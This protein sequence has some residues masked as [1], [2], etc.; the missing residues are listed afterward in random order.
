MYP[1]PSPEQETRHQAKLIVNMV[2]AVFLIIG[3]LLVLQHFHFIFLKDIPL[4][5]DWLLDL[6][7]R[8]F[9]P[10]MILIIHGEDSIGDWQLLRERLSRNFI[11]VSEEL[12]INEVSGGLGGG[13]LSPYSLIIV[14]DCKR[15]DKD[16]LLNLLEYVGT[17]GNLIWVG[18]AGTYGVVKYND[19]VLREQFGWDRGLVCINQKTLTSCNC[20]LASNTSDCKFLRDEAERKAVHFQ[21]KLG[22]SYVGS[23]NVQMPRIEIV[24]RNHWVTTGVK[25]AYDVGQV[26]K[27]AQVEVSYQ[28]SLLANIGFADSKYPALVSQ[29]GFG[30]DGMV[31]YFSYPPEETL[32]ILEPL[33]RRLRY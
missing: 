25:R 24:N 15:L 10:P 4:V 3:L 28:S 8:V 9:G 31:I 11:F 12:N 21:N 33:V 23:K 2:V 22:V 1:A 30:S 20:T 5:G 16:K 19:R 13:F 6:Y 7:E 27:I 18:D 32:E 17:G 14:E 29:D 26:D